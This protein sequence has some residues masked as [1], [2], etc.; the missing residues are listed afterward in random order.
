M[1]FFD[2]ITKRT[3][4]RLRLDRPH[5]NPQKAVAAAEAGP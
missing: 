3:T 2:F 5:P 4:C 1:A